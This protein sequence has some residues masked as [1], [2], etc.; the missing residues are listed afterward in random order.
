VVFSPAVGIGVAAAFSPDSKHLL[1]FKKNPV[2]SLSP[3]IPEYLMALWDTGTWNEHLTLGEEGSWSFTADGKRLALGGRTSKDDRPFLKIVEVATGNVV[4]SFSPAR[5]V[6]DIAL[7]PKGELLAVAVPFT[8]LIDIWD[9]TG[10][11]VARTL[12]GHTGWMSGIAMTPD[13]KTLATCSLDRTIKFWDPRADADAT[14][15]PDCG[16]LVA[17]DAAFRPDGLQVAFVQ[18]DN[19]PLGSAKDVTLW[20]PEAGKAAHVLK[21]HTAGARRVAYSADGTVVASGGRDATVRT[22]D[23]HTGRPLATFRGHIGYIEGL[24]VSSNGRWVASSSEPPELTK[25]RFGKAHAY[26]PAPGEVKVWDAHTGA[27]RQ[28]LAGNAGPVYQTA[29]S[30]DGRLLASGDREGM[31]KLWDAESGAPGGEIKSSAFAGLLFSPDSR[32]LAVVDH[33]IGG[34]AIILWDVAAGREVARLS[35]HNAGIFGGLAFSPDG[36]RAVSA[37]GSEVKL[38]EIPSGREIV[39]LPVLDQGERPEGVAA[40][41]F[42]A[43]GRRLLAAGSNGSVQAWDSAEIPSASAVGPPR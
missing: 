28:T 33:I 26:K 3:R 19:V 38:W 17:S 32:L 39:T 43:D 16:A 24:A 36:K 40:V 9:V 30:P 4:E 12:R 8:A 21:G 15:L 6:G 29:F 5:A 34:D 7:D 13:G 20:D 11:K 31:V 22:W 27:E 42:T 23:V 10:K 2:P 18:G 37:R 25:S 1:S 35:G 41:A 14:R